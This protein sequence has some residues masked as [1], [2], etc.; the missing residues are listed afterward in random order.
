MGEGVVAG[1]LDA[2]IKDFAA[3]SEEALMAHVAMRRVEA[4]EVPV[5]G[6]TAVQED[7][8][9]PVF[10]ANGPTTTYARRRATC[11]PGR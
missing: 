8:E 3:S 9:R 2:L 5:D 6:G 4:G 10:R 1:V 11:S 7:P